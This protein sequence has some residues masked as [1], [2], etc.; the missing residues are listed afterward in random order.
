MCPAPH[1]TV[2]AQ[3][4]TFPA[5]AVVREELRVKLLELVPT[6]MGSLSSVLG[7]DCV[8]SGVLKVLEALQCPL[9]TKNLIYTLLDLLLLELFP[10]DPEL[11]SLLEGLVSLSEQAHPQ[12]QPASGPVH[13]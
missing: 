8:E 9:L 1:Y 6:L 12:P 3:F 11:T 5:S 10:H 2:V 13:L 7:Q 4:L